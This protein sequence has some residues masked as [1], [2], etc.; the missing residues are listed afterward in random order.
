M[1]GSIM[2]LPRLL[3]LHALVTLA[4]GVVL[5]VAPGVIP[6]FVD[7]PVDRRA[8]LLCY[9]LGAAEV[10]LAV[11][12]YGSRNLSDRPAIRL[13][14]LT[15]IAFHALTAVVEVYAFSQGASARVWGNVGVRAVVVGLFIH[16][17]FG[18]INQNE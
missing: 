5:I 8:N 18:K 17:G 6:G 2:N 1:N 13:I 11:L 9:L 16:Y 7:I 15:F 10:S 12:S 4:A 14:C 3:F